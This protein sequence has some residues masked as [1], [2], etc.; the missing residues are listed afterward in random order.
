M[1]FNYT[2]CL[3]NLYN[4]LIKYSS[5][6]GV[7]VDKDFLSVSKFEEM[8]N[9]DEITVSLSTT[10]SAY[11]TFVIPVKKSADSVTFIRVDNKITRHPDEPILY[12]GLASFMGLN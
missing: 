10:G 7:Q 1:M 4:D 9:N 8:L 2:S 6:I 5:S 12:N 11:K 3:T